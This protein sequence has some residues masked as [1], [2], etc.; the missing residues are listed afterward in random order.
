MA[1]G[2]VPGYLGLKIEPGARLRLFHK[3]EA[4]SSRSEAT[5]LT[6]ASRGGTLRLRYVASA[7]VA[8]QIRGRNLIFFDRAG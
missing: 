3:N 8:S 1:I 6:A 2:L 7:I 4:A 5:G